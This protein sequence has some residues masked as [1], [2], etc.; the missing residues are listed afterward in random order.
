MDAKQNIRLL[1]PDELK[2]FFIEIGEKGFRAK[3]VHEWLWKKSAL[4]FDDMTNLSIKTWNSK[5]LKS[6]KN[7]KM[8]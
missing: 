1:S 8:L 5:L 3:Q 7:L 6:I 2:P 4:S